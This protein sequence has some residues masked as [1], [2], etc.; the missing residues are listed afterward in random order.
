M[1]YEYIIVGGGIGGLYT[2]YLLNKIFN[3]SNIL[4]VEKQDHLGGRIDTIIDE[5]TDTIIELGPSRIPNNQMNIQNL[6]KLLDLDSDLDFGKSSPAKFFINLGDVSYGSISTKS[7]YE[8]VDRIISLDDKSEL[9]K[10]ITDLS[11]KIKDQEFCKLANSYSLYRLIERE[12]DTKTAE[13]VK[14]QFGYT[15]DILYQNSL[16]ALNMFKNEFKF[17]NRYNSL[18]HGLVQIVNKLYE[19]L[20]G[21]WVQFMFD[22]ELIDIGKSKENYECFISNKQTKSIL[23]CNEIVLA[24]PKE[25]LI[26]INYLRSLKESFDTVINKPLMRVYAF[27]PIT[28]DENNNS[29][30]WFDDLAG[31]LITNT[32]LR[33]IIPIDKSKGLIMIAYCDDEPADSLNELDKANNIIPE[34][35]FHLNKLFPNKHIPLPTKIY[36]KY[37]ST[38][39]HLW[40]PSVDIKKI[41]DQMI[42]PLVNEDIFIVGEAYSVVHGWMEG[43]LLTVHKFIKYKYESK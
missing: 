15:G 37:W 1:T 31:T 25:S 13:L 17:D 43:A 7:Y 29:K 8:S 4:V 24:I 40:N 20:T 32:L 18:K 22:T 16:G 30:V 9:H 26:L 36:R 39:A 21:V 5:E 28:K 34:I 35:M 27:F 2:A 38:G 3:K 11:E 42:K 12:Y 33:Q 14:D 23:N 6:L 19:Y 41:N 10:V